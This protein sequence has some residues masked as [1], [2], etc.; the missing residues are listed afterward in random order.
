MSPNA[1]RYS[2]RCQQPGCL[3]PAIFKIAAAWS[4]GT[5]Q[6]LKTYALTCS[7]H[8]EHLLE[9]ARQRRARLRLEHEERVDDVALYQLKPR[10]NDTL[11]PT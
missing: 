11:E 1:F 10:G 6:E 9:M 2:P 8:A 7:D 5:F 4:D 3:S